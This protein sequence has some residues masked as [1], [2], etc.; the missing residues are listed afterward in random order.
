MG[1]DFMRLLAGQ[2]G[3]SEVVTGAEALIDEIIE[4]DSTTADL[5]DGCLAEMLAENPAQSAIRP[6]VIV[7]GLVPVRGEAT[8]VDRDERS[9]FKSAISCAMRSSSAKAWPVSSE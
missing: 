8:M 3:L 9:G 7:F 5:S 2:I 4:A 6:V 1:F